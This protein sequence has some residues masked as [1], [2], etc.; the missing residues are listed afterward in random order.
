MRYRLGA[1]IEARNP[2]V[3]A[4]KNWH[5]RK[6]QMKWAMRELSGRASSMHA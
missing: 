1:R 4:R 3:V 5:V 6:S 2:A